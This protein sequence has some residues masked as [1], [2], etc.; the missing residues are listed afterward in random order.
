M[1]LIF[2]VPNLKEF[3][4]NENTNTLNLKKNHQ[5]VKIVIFS[6]NCRNA[7]EPVFLGG[8]RI[9]FWTL[10]DQI[11]IL[12]KIASAKHF[13]Y[14]WNFSI[15]WLHYNG[16][17]FFWGLCSQHSYCDWWEL[18]NHNQGFLAAA[19]GR[20]GFVEHVVLTGLCTYSSGKFGESFSQ[21]LNHLF[22]RLTLARKIARFNLSRLFHL[23]SHRSMRTSY[24]HPRRRAES[25]IRNFEKTHGKCCETSPEVHKL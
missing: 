1:Y 15:G 8:A 11:G 9:H 6:K 14:L 13:R 7:G 12:K 17:K 10:S 24:R 5:K 4:C 21:P 2:L 20:I 19:N 22:W 25:F 16:S 18:Q 3:D 23:G